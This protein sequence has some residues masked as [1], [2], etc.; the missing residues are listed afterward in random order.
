MREYIQPQLDLAINLEWFWASVINGDI[1]PCTPPPFSMDFSYGRQD[2][3]ELPEIGRF[4]PRINQATSAMNAS[5]AAFQ[6]CGVLSVDDTYEAQANAI[7]AKII[8]RAA[9]DAID[10]TEKLIQ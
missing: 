5:I 9:L 10:D 1:Q 3:R 8:Y 4:A 2:L 7:N 6:R